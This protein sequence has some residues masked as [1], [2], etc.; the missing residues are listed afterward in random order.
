MCHTNLDYA[1]QS[2]VVSDSQEEQS[3]QK[4]TCFDKGADILCGAEN[5][6][7]RFTK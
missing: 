1:V 5:I 7:H 6:K 4:F 2:S 3:M